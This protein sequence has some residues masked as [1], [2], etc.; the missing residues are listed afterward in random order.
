MQ[1]VRSPASQAQR[2][3][4]PGSCG[5]DGLWKTRKTKTRFPSLPTALGNRSRDSHIPT[6]PARRGKVE[7]VNHVSHFPA[8]C[9][10]STKKSQKE[11]LAA[12]RFA[13]AFRLIL[14]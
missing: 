8:C 4:K 3:K 10:I 11:A 2:M 5:N 14:Q 1:A 13:P 9:L 12:D 6:A 7:N